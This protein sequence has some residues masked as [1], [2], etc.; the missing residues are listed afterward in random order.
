MNLSKNE[1][2]VGD[3]ITS[4]TN[5]LQ[6][7]AFLDF[8]LCQRQTLKSNKVLLSNTCGDHYLS[9]ASASFLQFSFYLCE[10][11]YQRQILGGVNL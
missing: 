1:K 2:V 5:Q 11:I 4:H 8:F 7:L 6:R 3:I 9:Y 10:R